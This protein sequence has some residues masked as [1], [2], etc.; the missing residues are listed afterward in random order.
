M[1]IG[2]S[3]WTLA[4]SMV[5]ACALGS[6]Q[7]AQ[8][9]PVTFEFSGTVV[10]YSVSGVSSGDTFSGSF[11]YESSTP[12]SNI[13]W[14][15]SSNNLYDYYGAIT[16]VSFTVGSFSGRETVGSR[17]SAPPISAPPNVIVLAN[18]TPDYFAL[19]QAVSGPSLNGFSP[20][21]IWL[22]MIDQ[23][24]S[25]LTSSALPT[26]F[27]APAYISKFDLFLDNG[28]FFSRIGGDITSLTR[29]SSV[30]EPSS[31]LLLGTGMLGLGFWR[32]RE[33]RTA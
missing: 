24:G 3:K 25:M 2:L 30:P 7:A 15:G 10:D 4:G 18:S 33:T 8:A 1:R 22:S 19:G 29:V 6:G 16:S 28:H 21:Y 12:Y 11:T 14:W 23:D 5:A 32:W 27:A 31:L 9:V 20:A 13:R 17:L 26:A